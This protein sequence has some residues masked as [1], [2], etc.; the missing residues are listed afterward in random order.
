MLG[1]LN[2]MC[3]A[4]A[5]QLVGEDPERFED[6]EEFEDEEEDATHGPHTA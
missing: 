1:Q 5:A 4:G 2:L 3:V 6:D